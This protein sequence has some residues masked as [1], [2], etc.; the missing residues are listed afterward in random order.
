MWK[1]QS[2]S[3]ITDE[4]VKFSIFVGNP[5]KA[6]LICSYVGYKTVKLI[7][8]SQN[9]LVISLQPGDEK[10]DDIVV[11]AYGAQKKSSLTAAVHR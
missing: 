6:A 8:S 7:V 5:S 11:V 4:Q 9:S 2:R 1:G 10:L 3:V